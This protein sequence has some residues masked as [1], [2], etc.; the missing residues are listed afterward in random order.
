[1]PTTRALPIAGL[2]LTLL[3][4]QATP[5]REFGDGSRLALAVAVSP[6]GQLVAA[7]FG[8]GSIHVWDVRSG[9]ELARQSGFDTS[10]ALPWA[11]ERIA[12]SSDG[13]SIAFAGDD[14]TVRVWQPLSDTPPRQLRGHEWPVRHLLFAPDGV[15][16]LTASGGAGLHADGHL[17]PS[18]PLRVL[19]YH[20]PSG[21]VLWRLD[22][23]ETGAM[24]AA[25]S[26]D[27]ESVAYLAS[28]A[29]AAST[30]A[31]TSGP[32]GYQIIIRTVAN[33]KARQVINADD[34]TLSLQFSPDGAMLFCG[35]SA[36]DAYSGQRLH[37][38]TDVPLTF[39]DPHTLL[40]IKNGGVDAATAPWLEPI[41]VDVQSRQTRATAKQFYPPPRIETITR[42]GCSPDFRWFVD[43]RLRVWPL[44]G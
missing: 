43:G 26:P 33:D 23:A 11:S 34:A 2:L 6:G 29:G 20:L 14:L 21:R 13:A 12:F 5:P 3:G 18:V 16:L 8:D 22:E 7:G 40:V 19:S 41:Y 27:G 32:A 38:L 30:P 28:D 25:F 44:P 17:G 24:N 37:R 4:C 39:V 31:P 9:Q 1:M 15:R 36:W 35:T 42:S 10:P